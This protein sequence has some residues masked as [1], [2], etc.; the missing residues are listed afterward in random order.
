MA[1]FGTDL[2]SVAEPLD[3]PFATGLRK[4]AADLGVVVV[5]GLFEPAEDGRV[6]NTLLVTGPGVETSYRKIH[7]YDAFGSRESDTVAP[8]KELV[9]FDL[10]RSDDRAGDVLRPALRGPVHR[11]RPARCG[12]DRRTGV[13]GCGSGQGRAVGS[14]DAG[15]GRGRAGLGAGVRPGLRAA[16]RHGS[17]RHRP[18]QPDHS[19]W[20][21]V[22]LR[23]G[24]GADIL[25]GV[26]D[27]EV[28]RDRCR[29]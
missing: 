20:A 25:H 27:S 13:V 2:A 6:H 11:T 15:A 8:G 16:G 18:E 19:A 22:L 1:C 17:A 5:A 10:S 3:G 4:A 12:A 7:L 21:D 23:L 14:A 28:V 9:T 26:V 24:A 29:L